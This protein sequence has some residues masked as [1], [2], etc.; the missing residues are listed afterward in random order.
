MLTYC[1][2]QDGFSALHFASAHGHPS[3]VELF[4]KSGAQLDIQTKVHLVADNATLYVVCV[5]AHIT[6]WFPHIKSKS[7]DYIYYH[8]RTTIPGNITSSLPHIVTSVK[9]E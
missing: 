4:I 9:H 6:S 5:F 3:I 8:S 7:D 1:S 2:I